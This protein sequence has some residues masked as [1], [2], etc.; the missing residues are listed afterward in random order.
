MTEIL[1]MSR[2]L[3]VDMYNH[4]QSMVRVRAH[5]AAKKAAYFLIHWRRRYRN[6]EVILRGHQHQ[7]PGM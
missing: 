3:P 1:R 4:L 7:L 2:G 5:K 6:N